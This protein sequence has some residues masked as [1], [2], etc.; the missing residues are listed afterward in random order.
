[1]LVVFFVGLC[2][3]WSGFVDRVFLGVVG[4]YWWCFAHWRAYWLGES[5]PSALWGWSS[6]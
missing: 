5:Q 2:M 1:M 3:A 4:C 6:L